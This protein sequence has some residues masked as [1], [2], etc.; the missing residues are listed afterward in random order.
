MMVA[1]GVCDDAGWFARRTPMPVFYFHLDGCLPSPDDDGTDLAG[2]AEAILFAEE[3]A[4][5]LSRNHAAE[6]LFGLHIVIF[7]EAGNEVKQVPMI[8]A[9]KRH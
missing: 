2:V 3:M 9:R 8:P 1:C 4:T 5:R 6:D 7:D